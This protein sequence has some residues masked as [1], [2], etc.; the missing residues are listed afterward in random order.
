MHH[1]ESLRWTLAQTSFK[2]CLVTQLGKSVMILDQ[3]GRFGDRLAVG[4][5]L[6]LV[7]MINSYF[8]LVEYSPLLHRL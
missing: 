6:R 7:R 3:M 1:L 5:R 2:L 8:L 4:R